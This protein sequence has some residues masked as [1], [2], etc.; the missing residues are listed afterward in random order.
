MKLVVAGAAGLVGQNLIARLDQG[1]R[2]IVAIDKNAAN[3]EILRRFHPK[4]KVV[5][6][7]FAEPGRWE[8]EL[9]D[10]ATLVQC[11]AQIGDLDSSAF[12]RNNVL[13]TRRLLDVA[14]RCGVGHLVHISS[15]VVNPKAVDF[16]TET[17]KS[18]E[19]LF[20]AC[21]I[22]HIVLRPTLMFGWFDRKHLGWLARFMQKTPVFPV[23]GNGRFLRQPL[24]VGDFCAVVASAIEQRTMGTYD[25]TGQERIDYIDLMRAVNGPADRP[26]R[27]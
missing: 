5:I 10:C 12:E 23:P 21:P 4:V 2:E 16:Y 19:R 17:K 22:P 9:E 7:D 6:V 27:S 13:S 25:I 20:D 3:I 15:S 26:R 1:D 24:Y 11:Q 14:Q 18:Q 8:T